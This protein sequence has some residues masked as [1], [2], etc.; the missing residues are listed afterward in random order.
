M[1][2]AYLTAVTPRLIQPGV[3]VGSSLKAGQ[4][5][6]RHLRDEIVLAHEAELIK[7]L[8]RGGSVLIWA[9]IYFTHFDLFR[10]AV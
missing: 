7:A 4:V 8:I 3:F 1:G 10:R 9:S 2:I 5:G 6:L